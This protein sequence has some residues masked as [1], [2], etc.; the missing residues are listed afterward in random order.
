MSRHLASWAVATF[1][2]GAAVTAA[3]VDLEQRATFSIP[4]QS[5][6]SALL[7]F[8]EQSKIQVLT[9]SGDIGR[10]ESRGAQGQLSLHD[11]LTSLLEGTG[12]VYQEVGERTITIGHRGSVPAGAQK[13]AADSGASAA[14]LRVAQTDTASSADAAKEPAATPAPESP[15]GQGDALEVVVTGAKRKFAP[16]ESSAATKIPMEIIEIPQSISVL[17]SELMSIVGAN[18]INKAMEWAPSVT[19]TAQETSLYNQAWVRGF[20]LSDYNSYK[21]NGMAFTGLVVP[22]DLAALDSIEIVRGPSAIIY[23]DSDYGGTVNVRLKKPQATRS[24]SGSLGG[25]VHGSSRVMADAT[26]ALTADGRLRGRLSLSYGDARSPQDFAYARSTTVAPS[27]SWDITDRDTLDVNLIW[28]RRPLRYAFGFGLTESNELPEVSRSAFVSS[29][30]AVGETRAKLGLV[31]FKHRFGE[32][33]TLTASGLAVDTPREENNFIG[34]D[35]VAQNGEVRLYQNNVR[36]RIREFAGELTLMGDFNAFGRSHTLALS[37]ATRRTVENYFSHDPGYADGV[38]NLN[39]SNPQDIIPVPAP[40]FSAALHGV[41]E[42]KALSGMLLLHP[43]SRTTVLLGLR[44]SQFDVEQGSFFDR[45]A[46]NEYENH[47]TNKRLGVVFE[48]AQDVNAYASYS[49]GTKPNFYTRT[50]SSRSTASTSRSMTPRHRP[51]RRSPS[52]STGRST[53]AWSSRPSASP[54]RASTSWPRTPTS[55]SRSTCAPGSPVPAPILSAGT[56]TS[57][58]TRRRTWPSSMRATRSSAA[59]CG[60]SV[61]GAESSVPASGKWRRPGSSSFLPTGGWMPASATTRSSTS[62]SPSMPST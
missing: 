40:A 43:F 32:S 27:L 49:D 10:I 57:S 39:D 62:P 58:R 51:M 16:Q 1:L 25:D 35:P 38:F 11:A 34:F 5:L 50:R 4:A 21:L 44:R 2:A 12:L 47:A 13:P 8:A 48:V 17:S 29:T 59:L 24:F 18:T 15:A 20:S 56:A 53:R 52:P 54:S 30:A 9:A 45:S 42:S 26:G 6:S 60:A 7:L 46:V 41:Q 61:W 33:W 19:S 23:G 55:T 14:G 36:S 22:L 28:Q 31:S 37:A 3:A